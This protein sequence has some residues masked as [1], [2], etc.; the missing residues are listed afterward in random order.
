MKYFIIEAKINPMEDEWN[1]GSK[2]VM[3]KMDGYLEEEFEDEIGL[4]KAK[5]YIEKQKKVEEEKDRAPQ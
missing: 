2:R 1:E 5:T 4:D 3:C